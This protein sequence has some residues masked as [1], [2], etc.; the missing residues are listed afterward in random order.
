MASRANVDA[1]S[2]NA[3][4]PR[5]GVSGTIWCHTAIL[6]H[7]TEHYTGAERDKTKG[8]DFTTSCAHLLRMTGKIRQEVDHTMTSKALNTQ[9]MASSV[10]AA[11]RCDTEGRSPESGTSSSSST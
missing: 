4:I 6:Q 10:T 3:N 1:A 11:L 8:N 7:D 2:A 9:A 5:K